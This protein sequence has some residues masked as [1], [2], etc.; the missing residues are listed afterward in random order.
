MSRYNN[1]PFGRSENNPSQQIL[2]T[3]G[4]ELD[5]TI[6]NVSNFSG[7]VVAPGIIIWVSDSQQQLDNSLDA[8]NL[9]TEGFVLTDCGASAGSGI[10]Y[11]HAFK[12]KLFARAGLVNANVQVWCKKI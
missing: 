4:K 9:P 2:D 8:T 7:S 6:E 3:L 10:V 11:L 12:G 1:L 5:I